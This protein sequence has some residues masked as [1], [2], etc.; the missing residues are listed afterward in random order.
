M[1]YTSAKA[2]AQATQADTTVREL[3]A[4][5]YSS[6]SADMQ[7][8]GANLRDMAQAITKAG[9]KCSKDTAGDFVLAH[10]LTIHGVIF[11]SAL[12]A[13]IGAGKVMRAHSLIANARKARGVEYVRSVL[14]TLEHDPADNEEDLAK[15]MKKAVRDLDAA[16]REQKKKS[17]PEPGLDSDESDELN[18][19]EQTD[20]PTSSEQL[21]KSL[22]PL[23]I[24]LRK[25]IEEGDLPANLDAWL[26]EVGA[27]ARLMQK[28]RKAA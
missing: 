20:E 10:S 14:R 24:A 28:A 18:E 8:E 21:V 26:A 3:W 27:I 6:A 13:R 12:S 17:E 4:H 15:A 16:K 5:A 22:T 19:P 1:Q 25:K 2:V 23:T 7:T 11:E 9:F